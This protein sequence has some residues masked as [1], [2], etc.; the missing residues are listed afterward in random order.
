MWLQKQAPLF[1][2]FALKYSVRSV[3]NPNIHNP[4]GVCSHVLWLGFSHFYHTDVIKRNL[5]ILIIHLN[6]CSSPIRLS[7]CPSP[8]LLPFLSSVFS[9][10]SWVQAR[11][12]HQWLP[13]FEVFLLVANGTF[14]VSLSSRTPNIHSW[15]RS[16]RLFAGMGHRQSPK[17]FGFEVPTGPHH[18]HGAFITSL[19]ISV[20]WIL[21]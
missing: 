9:F 19:S 20:Q 12:A 11:D 3:L 1:E 17:M 21:Q 8:A 18:L 14:E 5:K 2:I 13:S 16:P 6:L 15:K 4:S 7:L 10:I